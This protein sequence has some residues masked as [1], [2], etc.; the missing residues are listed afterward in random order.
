MPISGIA[1]LS[2]QFTDTTGGN[3]TSWLWDFGDGY[4]DT[5]QNPVHTYVAAGTYLVTQVLEQYPDWV[6]AFAT[7]QDGS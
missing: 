5:T 6:S 1:P 4:T 7:L 2:I 3:V